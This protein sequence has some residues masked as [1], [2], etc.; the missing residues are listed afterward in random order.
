MKGIKI[1]KEE[2]KLRPNT[3]IA[4]FKINRKCT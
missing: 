1:D 3:N 4:R 2:I